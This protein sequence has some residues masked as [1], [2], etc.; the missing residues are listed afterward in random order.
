MLSPHM[1]SNPA[2]AVFMNLLGKDKSAQ[3]VGLERWKTC[4]SR[5][6][7]CML[8]IPEKFLIKI[9]IQYILFFPSP[10]SS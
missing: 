10:N 3:M 5:R 9:V 2:I 4:V 6:A 8:E 1:V 7:I